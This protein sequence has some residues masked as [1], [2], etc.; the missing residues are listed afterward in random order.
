[1]FVIICVFIVFLGPDLSAFGWS[2]SELECSVS[3][4]AGTVDLND[5][6]DQD[7]AHSDILPSLPCSAQ[8]K[9]RGRSKTSACRKAW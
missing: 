8:V 7:D 6:D 5:D 4:F 3:S 2:D 9:K 1:M